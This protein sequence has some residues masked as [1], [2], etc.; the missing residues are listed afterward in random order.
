MSTSQQPVR[1][2]TSAGPLPEAPI[3]PLG[4]AG[5]QLSGARSNRE[6]RSFSTTPTTSIT[7]VTRTQS[8]F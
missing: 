4:N 3:P 6:K 2:A 7:N 8:I 5:W 1:K